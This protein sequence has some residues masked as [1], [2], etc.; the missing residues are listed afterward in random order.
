[1]IERPTKDTIT[2]H[3]YGWY[4]RQYIKDAKAKGAIP[5][6][7]SL[8]P[9]NIWREGKVVRNN[10]TYVLWA[11]Q[12]A[13]QEGAYFIDLHNMLC[14]KYDLM[15]GAMVAP[16]FYGDHTHTSLAGAQVN[17]MMVSQGIKQLAGCRLASFVEQKK[18]EE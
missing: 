3:T 2:V 15:G 14:D 16:Y 4:I 12:A 10:D 1:M 11:R 9:R 6:V 8:I 17:A 7:V 5:I 13:E 18:S